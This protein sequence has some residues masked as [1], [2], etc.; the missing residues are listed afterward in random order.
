MVIC[1]VCACSNPDD[2]ISCEQCSN[3]FD[4]DAR[5]VVMEAGYGQTNDAS[6]P[7]RAGASTAGASSGEVSPGD[8]LA[9]RYEILERLGQG[10]MGT[11]Y[12]A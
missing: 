5:T 8:V 7:A 11:V 3:P 2:S 12:K 9:D 6:A 10:G 4:L 1:P